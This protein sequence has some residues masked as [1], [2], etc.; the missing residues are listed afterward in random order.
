MII[1]R[2]IFWVRTFGHVQHLIKDTSINELAG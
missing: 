2:E 1:E